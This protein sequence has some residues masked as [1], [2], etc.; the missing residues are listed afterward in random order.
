M[1]ALFAAI[2]VFLLI[3]VI[4]CER[5]QSFCTDDETK[6]K[7]R[8][9]FTQGTTC[10]SKISEV[11]GFYNEDY[12]LE[13]QWWQDLSSPPDKI[14]KAFVTE[15]FP[16][17]NGTIKYRAKVCC[18]G[19]VTAQHVAFRE[20][21]PLRVTT[22]TLQRW[23]GVPDDIG[24]QYIKDCFKVLRSESQ[25]HSKVERQQ[26]PKAARPIPSC[27][28]CCE[29][30]FCNYETPMPWP[31]QITKKN[32]CEA[33]PCLYNGECVANETDPR[34]YSCLCKPGTWGPRCQYYY[35]TCNDDAAYCLNGGTCFDQE[36][37]G[38]RCRCASG[39]IGTKCE[40]K[41]VHGHVAKVESIALRYCDRG[42]EATWYS[43]AVCC[44]ACMSAPCQNDGWC[45]Q[46]G[47]D[48]VC[49]CRVGYEGRHCENKVAICYVS[50]DPHYRTFDGLM[51]H[52]QGVC[53]Y[54]LA[55]SQQHY[56][57]LPYF[58]VLAK[59]EHRYGNTHVSYTRYVDVEVFGHTVR[60]N[61]GKKVYVDGVLVQPD[62]TYPGFEITNNGRFVRLATNFSLVVES[63]GDWLS[64]VKAPPSFAGKMA[65]LCGNADGN[66]DNDWRT[67][68]GTNVKDL[69]NKYSLIGN[70]WQVED[71]EEANCTTT[72]DTDPQECDEAEAMQVSGNT[73]CGL[74]DATDGI[75][76]DC[77]RNA[78][79]LAA[80]YLENCR[81]DVC[82]NMAIATSAKSA[83]CGT[84][85]AFSAQCSDLGYGQVDWR[86]VA[87]CP[88]DCGPDMVY[89]LS[90]PACLPT[91][92]KPNAPE[93]CG[94]PKTESCVCADNNAVVV[95]GKCVSAQTC[96]CTDDNGVHHEIGAQWLNDG[97]T[98][99]LEC[100]VCQSCNRP[101]GEIVSRPNACK[102]GYNCSHENGVAHCQKVLD[103]GPDMV[104]QLSAPACL[105][106]CSKPNAPEECGLPKTESCVCANN[107]SVVVDGKCV[108]A[109]T[110]GC[111]DDNGVHYAIGAQ[112]LN[113]G[114]TMELECVVCQSCNRPVGE[115]VAR[116]STCEE[117]YYCSSVNGV[118]H[119]QKAPD[120]GPDMVYQL[121]AP[122]CLA[123]C[124]KPNAPEE[125]G[126]PKTDSCVC[127]D[128]DSV[129]VDGKCVSAQTCGCTDDNG[130]HYAIGAQW[131]NDGCTME[132]KCVVCQSC[133]RPVGEIVSRPTA[134][135]NGY[136]CFHENGVAHCQKSA[137]WSEWL[138]WGDCS[139][140]CGKGIQTR[141][142]SCTKQDH[143]V[144][145]E[146][147][148]EGTAS[149]TRDCVC[150][151]NFSAAVDCKKCNKT[152][153][154]IGY[155]ADK[156]DC[157]VYYQCHL[158][159]GE[160][161]ATHMSCPRCQ[162][163]DSAMLTCVV[164]QDT[165]CETVTTSEVTGQICNLRTVDNDVTKY[166][167][168]APGQD[169]IMSCPVGTVFSLL[170][171]TCVW[172]S[173]IHTTTQQT[174][175]TTAVAIIPEEITCVNFDAGWNGFGATH[176]VYV[177]PI[178]VDRES[179][180]FVGSAAKFNGS[181]RLE[182][183]RFS[184][185][186]GNWKQFA[187][188]FCYKRSSV[189][190][191]ATQGLVSNGNCVSAP[192]ISITSG[193]GTIAA[194]LSTESGTVTIS[195]IVA[196][197]N[198]WHHVVL[199]YDGKQVHLC[200]D[201]TC[202]LMGHSHGAISE[203]HCPM[204]IGQLEASRSGFIGYMDE[205]CFYQKAL[206]EGV[207]KRLQNTFFPVG[208]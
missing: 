108:S 122:A 1:A 113:D 112:W 162:H 77:I 61:K 71:Q 79:A 147:M 7:T 70:S 182:I 129:V 98:M 87:G 93:E 21:Q 86:T 109:Q 36:T 197:D 145:D 118:A 167:V 4:N 51:L 170:K 100:V 154:Y 131:L 15:C 50:G 26:M 37:F 97:C 132:L 81:F 91:C 173:S 83:A 45:I 35:P 9:I 85:E 80:S 191:T 128:N 14:S 151:T 58:Q 153:N 159:N 180:A 143:S 24:V 133:N 144:V 121:S 184:N 40:I 49:Q 146:A 75:F 2:A 42:D 55:S 160:W 34:G 8:W 158:A 117:G 137:Q 29:G 166:A 138:S 185:S 139:E 127:A 18:P 169:V 208:N 179:S 67:S 96:G 56:P 125:C 53:R 33:R 141:K 177:Q 201:G 126:L 30:P 84:L 65:G 157:S 46:G 161:T 194:H 152:S 88:L 134:C 10:A 205:L 164:S 11:T 119:C 32:G 89:Q 115:I 186:Y 48:Y 25:L 69:P 189:G 12:R 150:E 82:A 5:D 102:D 20:M 149:D 60:L 101:V 196:A 199:S 27:T 156:C 54:N 104:Y 22:R 111:T 163:W 200:V 171:C 120:C 39:F 74:L 178:N 66:A 63:D 148:C 204:V 90:A 116:A 13:C 187:V 44:P 59:S 105:P 140:S 188:S 28:Y 31:N 17:I 130:V 181:G 203:R 183:P 198:V 123:T 103:C 175:T 38:R 72:N 92:S 172:A 114:C 73:Y 23:G 168:P 136:K 41:R 62:A 16:L 3:E 19:A 107:N 165:T 95:D 99:E 94:L 6:A 192:S 155:V 190:G 64:V 174:L 47:D 52:Y 110:C 206:P 195:G 76:R 202:Y 43:T 193:Q 124:S 78:P 135:K 176:W 68:N 57:D 142:R 207:V 106:T